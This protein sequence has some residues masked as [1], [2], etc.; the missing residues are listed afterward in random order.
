MVTL[1]TDRL[2]LRALAETD[3]DA[4]IRELNDFA[5]ARNLARV[6]WPYEPHHAR[7]F[8]HWAR[9]LDHRTLFCAVEEKSSPGKLIGILSYEWSEAAQDAVFGYWYC[10]ASWGRGIATEAGRTVIAHAFSVNKHPLLRADYHLDN[11]ASGNVLHKLGFIE[12]GPALH[13]SLAQGRDIPSMEMQL[14]RQQ[15]LADPNNQNTSRT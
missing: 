2:L 14:T 1:T 7:E 3:A 10:K 12:K 4:L 8:L 5:I 9:S 11:P 6:P 13:H 15:W